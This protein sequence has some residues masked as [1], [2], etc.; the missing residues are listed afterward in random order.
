[1]FE[2]K[3]CKQTI[4]ANIKQKTLTFGFIYLFIFFFFKNQLFAFIL[5]FLFYF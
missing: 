2:K 3:I 1:M 5:H 4:K